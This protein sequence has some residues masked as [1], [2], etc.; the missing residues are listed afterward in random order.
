MIA[1]TSLVEEAEADCRRRMAIRAGLANVWQNR[2]RRAELL[3][4]IDAA[5]DTYL[6]L[7]RG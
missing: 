2:A 4:E 7:A 3:A 1:G 5:L 6:R